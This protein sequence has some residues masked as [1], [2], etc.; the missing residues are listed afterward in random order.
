MVTVAVAFDAAGRRCE[1]GAILDARDRAG[2]GSGRRQ[3]LARRGGDR[4]RYFA[5]RLRSRCQRASGRGSEGKDDFEHMK[6]L[7][8]AIAT[9]GQAEFEVPGFPLPA[10]VTVNGTFLRRATGLPRTSASRWSRRWAR[11][12]IWA[13]LSSG[14]KVRC[15]RC[16]AGLA[17]HTPR[18]GEAITTGA[19]SL[20]FC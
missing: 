6:Q 19:R 14:T 17:S 13:R 1:S 16:S 5:R 3:P 10:I 7:K 18:R 11:A 15:T 12:T 2:R 8:P 20:T 4:R 9:A